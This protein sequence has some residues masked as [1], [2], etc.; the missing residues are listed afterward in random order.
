MAY[1]YRRFSGDQYDLTDFRGPRPGDKAP[2][3]ELSL[4]DGT[5]ARLLDFDGRFLVLETGSITCPLFQG[6]RAGMTSLAR[7]YP[8]VSFAVLYVREAHPGANLPAH[9]DESDKLRH[10]RMLAGEDGEGRRI[11]VDDFEGHAHLAYGGYPNSVFIINRNGCVVWAADWNNPAATARALEA[12]MAGRPAAIRAVFKP[13]PPS[14]SL[15]ILRRSGQGALRDFLRSLPGLI[16]SNAIRRNLRLG[17]HAPRGVAP[18][19][20]C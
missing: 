13:V 9:A 3:F 5:P 18:D 7:K 14:V 20:R 16:W 10:A 11:L 15:R 6:R 4:P 2:D 17:R 12:L 8:D 19:T 1:N